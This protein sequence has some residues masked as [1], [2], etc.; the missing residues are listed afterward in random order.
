MTEINP[1]RPGEDATGYNSSHPICGACRHFTLGEWPD[2]F[3][4]LNPPADGRYPA[5][6]VFT[7]LC[8]QFESESPPDCE[9]CIHLRYGRGDTYLCCAEPPRIGDDGRA[10]W[11]EVAEN[12]QGCAR[13]R[14]HVEYY[15]MDADIR[16]DK[17]RAAIEGPRPSD[18]AEV[19]PEDF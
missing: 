3:C 10:A 16:R 19:A 17:A 5:A 4:R 18:P 8:G 14:S 6:H 9:S 1:I 12:Q 13:W 7:L 11:P 15:E 2:G